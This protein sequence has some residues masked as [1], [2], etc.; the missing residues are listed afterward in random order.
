MLGHVK[1][2]PCVFSLHGC[3]P[4]SRRTVG[5]AERPGYLGP[6]SIRAGYDATASCRNSSGSFAGRPL[7]ASFTWDNSQDRVSNK[8]INS[9]D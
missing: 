8:R 7:P 5:D 3:D 1:R 4:R 6:R 9:I 2:V